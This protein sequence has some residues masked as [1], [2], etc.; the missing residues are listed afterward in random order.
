MHDQFRAQLERLR[1]EA[2]STQPKSPEPVRHGNEMADEDV[3]PLTEMSQSIASS[4]N[5]LSAVQLRNIEA[6]LEK[7]DHSPDDYGLC[8][9]CDEPIGTRR[10][11]RLPWARYCIQCQS[12]R[13]KGGSVTRKNL[14]DY[15]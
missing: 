9:A 13:E 8:E 14:T 1:A 4:R 2:L 6:A 15:R 12:A 10:L 7:I 3:Q 5:A 11:E